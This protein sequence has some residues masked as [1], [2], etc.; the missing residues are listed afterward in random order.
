MVSGKDDLK[1]SEYVPVTSKTA[2]LFPPWFDLELARTGQKF[3]CKYFAQL[4]FA[5][6]MS[7]VVSLSDLPTRRALFL[8]RKSNTPE[9]AFKR[10]VSTAQ[11]V[12]LWYHSDILDPSWAKSISNVREIHN[13]ASNYLE[14]L[15]PPVLKSPVHPEDNPKDFQPNERLWKAFKMDLAKLNYED[16]PT[17]YH[18]SA[19]K[20]QFKQYGWQ[21]A[22]WPFVA[23]PI[24][25]PETLGIEMPSDEKGLQG[26]IHLWSV[27]GYALGTDEENI[28][29][30]DAWSKNEWQ[31]CK[32]HLREILLKTF[33]PQLINLDFEGK[34]MI[35]S[36]LLVIQMFTF[37]V[38]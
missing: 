2:P 9:R 4:V 33:L 23:L 18:Y 16:Q 1:L 15:N 26:F 34:T 36:M 24:L 31:G 12:H 6:I 25:N 21:M 30:K 13:Y 22:I 14:S 38:G 11:Q 19:P 37:T 5:N 3:S 35:E 28:Y 17:D 7:L 32:H 29:C 10:Y 27:I 20:F 8:T